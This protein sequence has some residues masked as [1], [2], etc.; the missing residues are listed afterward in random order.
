MSSL[1]LLTSVRINYDSSGNVVGDSHNNILFINYDVDMDGKRMV[2]SVEGISSL[3]STKKN[4][5][6]GGCRNKQ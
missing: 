3:K 5:G 6:S 4:R 2:K 1:D